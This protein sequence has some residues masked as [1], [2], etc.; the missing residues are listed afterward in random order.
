VQVSLIYHS[1]SSIIFPLNQQTVFMTKLLI[2]ALY[3]SS[4]EYL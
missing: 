4:L 1:D 2:L 3:D